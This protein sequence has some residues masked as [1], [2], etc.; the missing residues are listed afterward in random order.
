MV[1]RLV[2]LG[3]L[4]APLGGLQIHSFQFRTASHPGVPRVRP[5]PD[6]HMPNSH[7]SSAGTLTVAQLV[8]AL[9]GLNGDGELSPGEKVLRLEGG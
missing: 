5:F 8:A 3:A 7:P 2:P 9:P 4:A 1:T 6:R